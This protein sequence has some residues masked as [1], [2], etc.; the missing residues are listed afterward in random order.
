MRVRGGVLHT[1]DHGRAAR[2]DGRDR[3]SQ[4]WLGNGW[5]QWPG[6][7]G[8][9]PLRGASQPGA[10][11]HIPGLLDVTARSVLRGRYGQCAHARWPAR[12]PARTRSARAVGMG[13]ARMFGGP[14]GIRRE[15]ALGARGRD[16]QRAHVRWSVRHPV[17]K[18][19]RCCAA[20]MGRARACLTARAVSSANARLAR[21]VSMGSARMPGGPR[22]IRRGCA[23]G[24]RGR[25]MGA[26]ACSIARSAVGADAWPLPTCARLWI[27]QGKHTVWRP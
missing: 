22:G 12:Y 19:A 3:Q 25:H 20:G 18:R 23:L 1:Q 6:I 8:F 7:A 14:R 26:R 2:P 10:C 15:C 21:A 5:G 17:R 4:I 24:A 13:S 27:R 16:R 9:L 11:A